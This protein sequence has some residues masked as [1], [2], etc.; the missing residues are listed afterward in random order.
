MRSAEIFLLCALGLVAQGANAQSEKPNLSGKWQL[1]SAK[2]E[3]AG[4]VSGANLSVEQKGPSIHVVK[5]V[6]TSDGKET[7]TEFN[8]TTDG[9]DCTTSNGM[10]VSLW[11]DGQSLVEMDITDDAVV[12]SSMSLGTDGKTISITVTHISPQAAAETLLLEKI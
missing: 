10:K 6:K 1:N 5:T 11:Y 7:V 2:S 9:K 8:C 12:K 3:K 4:K